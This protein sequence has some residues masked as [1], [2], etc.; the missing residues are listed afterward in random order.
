MRNY[1]YYTL[2]YLDYL[3]ILVVIML[4]I[5][6]L[7]FIYEKMFWTEVQWPKWDYNNNKDKNMI[8]STSVCNHQN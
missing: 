5:R 2:M 8:Q 4:Y 3:L 7:Y 1:H 6:L